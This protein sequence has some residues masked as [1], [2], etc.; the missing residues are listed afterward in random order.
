MDCAGRRRRRKIVVFALKQFCFFRWWWFGPTSDDEQTTKA[1]KDSVTTSNIHSGIEIRLEKRKKERE[2]ERER[3]KREGYVRVVM[4]SML[5]LVLWAVPLHFFNLF[6]SRSFSFSLV[7]AV[8][9]FLS[10]SL[11]LP[12]LSVH[13]FLFLSSLIILSRTSDL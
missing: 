11:S 12:P 13:H 5:N 9:Y 10:L 4:H 1:W 6:P 7:N 8:Q 3:G 2:G